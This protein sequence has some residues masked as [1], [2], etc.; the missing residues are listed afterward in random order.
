MHIATERATGSAKVVDIRLQCGRCIDSDAPSESDRFLRQ[1]S[2]TAQVIAI[3]FVATLALVAAL[4]PAFVVTVVE[5]VGRSG[6]SERT[7]SLNLGTAALTAGICC[8]VAIVIARRGG[9]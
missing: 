9:G 8:A 7:E 3:Q 4:S 5:R 2:G 1:Q 6:A